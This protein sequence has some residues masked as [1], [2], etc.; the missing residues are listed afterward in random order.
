MLLVRG[1]STAAVFEG[2]L[3]LQATLVLPAVDA[4]AT[5]QPVTLVLP[6]EQPDVARALALKFKYYQRVEGAFRVPPGAVLRSLTARAYES[7]QMKPQ[8]T[9]NLN[10]P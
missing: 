1:G 7:G 5:L 6:D 10:F 3:K 2:N 4:G 8:A 9:Q